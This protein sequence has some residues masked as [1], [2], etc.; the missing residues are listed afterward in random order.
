MAKKTVRDL[1]QV[2][3]K[4]PKLVAELASKKS[5]DDRVAI[6][7]NYK[8]ID[9]AADLPTKDEVD[10]Q[11]KQLFSASEKQETLDGARAA[12]AFVVFVVSHASD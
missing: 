1:L 5:T 12:L 9:S 8:V 2:V 4:N 7:K 10:G 3:G 11:L 6:L